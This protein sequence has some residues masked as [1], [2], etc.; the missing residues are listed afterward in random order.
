MILDRGGVQKECFECQICQSRHKTRPPCAK[1][2]MNTSPR[3]N[4][5]RDSRILLRGVEKVDDDEDATIRFEVQGTSSVY[6]VLLNLFRGIVSCDCPDF[7]R[8]KCKCK[9]MYFIQDRVLRAPS[10][11]TDDEVKL[12]RIA[13]ELLENRELLASVMPKPA[14]VVAQKP[15]TTTDECPICYEEFGKEATL[16][17]KKQCG[18]SFHKSCLLKFFKSGTN[19]SQQCPYCRAAFDSI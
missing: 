4:R 11:E 2:P 14:V 3:R 8:R 5:S 18:T 12:W 6:W 15:I 19:Y 9:H 17:C 7:Q 1:K 13:N 10:P 16:W